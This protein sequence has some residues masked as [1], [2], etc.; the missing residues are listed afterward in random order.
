MKKYNLSTITAEPLRIR[1]GGLY[2]VIV[3]F[4]IMV[5]TSLFAQPQNIDDSDITQAIETDL[6]VDKNVNMNTIDVQTNQGIVTLSGTAENIL[7]KERASQIA[8]RIVGVRA[9]VNLIDVQPDEYPT[10]TELKEAINNAILHD[11]ATET[12][13]ITIE[14]KNGAITLKGTVDSWQEKQLTEIVTKGIKG[15]RKVKNQIRV[16]LKEDRADYEI[17]Q[18]IKARLANDVRVDHFQIDVTVEN[19]EVSLS[20]AIGSINEKKVAINDSWVA[21]VRIVKSEDLNVEWW[22][23]DEMRRKQLY[24]SQ[25][26]ENIKKALKTAFLYDPRVMSFNP[27]VEVNDG[28]VL[29]KGTV[30]NLIAKQSAE[31]DAKNVIG[32]RRVKNHIKVQP[33][34]TAMGQD[35]KAEIEKALLADPYINRFAV[36]VDVSDG[37]VYLMGKVNTNFEKYRA[38]QIAQGIRGVVDVFNNLEYNYKWKWQRD[39]DIKEN[40]EEQLR[41]SLFVDPDDID[42]DVKNGVVTLTGE[43]ST[44]GEYNAA[45]K[46]AYEGGAKEVRN[47][48]TMMIPFYYGLYGNYPLWAPPLYNY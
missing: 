22:A 24:E 45:E 28:T 47:E 27:I 34:S 31:E 23:R 18:E 2:I 35:L 36:K 7:M 9:I 46:N 16:K 29:L 13:D 20:G 32:V 41:W 33:L 21:G 14:S 6:W 26:D 40:V 39:S 5:M 30:D 11:P 48:L 43:V 25:S 8:S 44:W 12:F 42:I 3:F 10:D 1:M 38:G 15:V 4:L 37:M 19:C 17:E